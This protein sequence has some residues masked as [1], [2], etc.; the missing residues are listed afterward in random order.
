MEAINHLQKNDQFVTNNKG[1]KV[2]SQKS[3]PFTHLGHQAK[4][5]LKVMLEHQKIYIIQCNAST[6]FSFVFLF[7][8]D[9]GEL[10]HKYISTQNCM[11]C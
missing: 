3:T 1:K 10:V 8:V 4:Q 2:N 5:V 11:M 6:I 9:A 7:L